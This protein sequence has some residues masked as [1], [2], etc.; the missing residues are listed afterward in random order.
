[1]ETE[2]QRQ[3]GHVNMEGKLSLV[4]FC[5]SINP[6]IR[7]HSF[8]NRSDPDYPPKFSSHDFIT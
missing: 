2:Q 8:V 1:M 5:K 7:N 3:A 4:S 6:I